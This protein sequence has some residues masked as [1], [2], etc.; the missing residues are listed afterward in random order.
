MRR[1]KLIILATAA[2]FT[3]T[4]QPSTD[5]DRIISMLVAD[6]PEI[7]QLVAANEAETESKA[8]ENMLENPSVDAMHA[9]SHNNVGN[10][11]DAGIS[12]GFAW[13]GVYRARA[14]AINAS[15][16]AADLL[17]QSTVADK[18]LQ[19]EQLVIDIVYQ[20]KTID[21]E[22]KILTHMTKLEK[23]NLDGFRQGELT[24]LD[25]VLPPQTAA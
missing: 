9:W 4:A 22:N 15:T 25:S 23:G 11:I 20:R 24:M 17:E 16:R 14:K 19:I 2:A 12:Q 18:I 1:V 8:A 6:C 3:S 21:V 10:K 7:K 5:Y 13:P